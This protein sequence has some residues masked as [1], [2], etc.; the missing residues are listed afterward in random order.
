MRKSTSHAFAAIALAASTL[1]GCSDGGPSQPTR[2]AD[3]QE[4]II[5]GSVDNSGL[6]EDVVAVFGAMSKCT[7][8]IIG[9]DEPYAFVLTAAHCV[10][11]SPPQVVI[12]GVDHNSGS[13]IQYSVD[14]YA[15][16]PGYNGS[17][18]D[19]AMIRIL[20][21]GPSTPVRS[22]MTSATDNLGFNSQVT[23]LG[24][25]VI[26]AN[27]DVDT[28]LRHITT[29]RVV[30]DSTLTLTF[31][32]SSS[33][34][35]FGDSGGP[36]I[37]NASGLVA[38]VNSSV[39]SGNCN[40]QSFSGRVSA[41]VDTFILPFIN[42]TPPPPVTCDACFDAATTGNG[43]CSSQVSACFQDATCST[44][45]DCFNDCQTQSCVQQCANT[46]SGGLPLYN[47]IF[48]CVCD[49]AC[50]DE[51][52]GSATCSGG[53]APPTSSSVSQS[54]VAADAAATTTT[55][56]AGGGTGVGGAGGAGAAP[57]SSGSGDNGFFAG[58]EE[59]QDID[60][61]IIQAAC[62]FDGSNGDADWAWLIAAA[63]V[64]IVLRRRRRT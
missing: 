64:G 5:N 57:S 48:D 42:N 25:G 43:A 40:G 10:E 63:A 31:D 14:D 12:Q 44:L 37:D 6:Y 27:P 51:C 3:V 60:G 11:D 56:S 34:V 50:M 38:G 49:S 45:V 19:F 46:H 54:S 18:N 22:V 9:K 21:A 41:V 26:G 17:V 53:T 24:Y 61:N 30:N 4:P 35:C 13:S 32:A 52:D 20:G 47:A 58:G 15:I 1:A 62:A 36:N 55:A 7:G 8:T 2:V 39:S 29:G 33:G 23:H 28:S 59:D 16:H